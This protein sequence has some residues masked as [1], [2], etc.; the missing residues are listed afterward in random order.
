MRVS[1]SDG[2]AEELQAQLR[3]RDTLDTEVERRLVETLHAPHGRVVLSLEELEEIALRLGTGLP[4]RNKQ[5]LQ[6]AIQQTAQLHLGD[7]RLTF[8]PPQLAQIEERAKKIGDTPERF[9]ARVASKLLTDVFLVQPAEEGIFYTPGF[10]PGD[11]DPVDD[12]G[13]P[14]PEERP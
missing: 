6:R 7:V 12:L 11:G 3:G 2:T 5:D 14:S 9:V 1:I 13:N 8:T 4:I 10:E